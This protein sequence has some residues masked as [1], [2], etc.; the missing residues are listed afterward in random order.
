MF[1]VLNIYQHILCDPIFRYYNRKICRVTKPR[2]EGQGGCS[3]KGQKMVSFTNIM[4]FSIYVYMIMMIANAKLQ[5]HHVFLE[6]DHDDK[7]EN[8]MTEG[9][10]CHCVFFCAVQIHSRKLSFY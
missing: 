3:E 5:Q 10:S 6:Y 4:C 2:R 1:V 7:A 8:I 9:I